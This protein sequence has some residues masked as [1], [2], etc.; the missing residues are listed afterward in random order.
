MRVVVAFDAGQHGHRVGGG[1]FDSVVGAAAA[2][3][4]VVARPR[5]VVPGDD[6]EEDAVGEI[7]ASFGIGGRRAELGFVGVSL[8]QRADHQ[9]DAVDFLT[10]VGALADRDR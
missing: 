5:D 6:A 8:E 4:V 9:G 7:I 2:A 10:A 1:G 3:E